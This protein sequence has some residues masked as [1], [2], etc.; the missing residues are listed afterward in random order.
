MKEK[1][2]KK[3]LVNA[4]RKK[5]GNNYDCI[6]PISGG[7]DSFFQAHVLTKKYNI[8]PLAVTFNHNWFSKTGF[9]IIYSYVWKLLT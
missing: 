8:K 1:I 4:K 9:S 3:I 5:S 7:K 2:L 6:L